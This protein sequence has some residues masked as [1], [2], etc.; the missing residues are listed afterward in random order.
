[1][2]DLFRDELTTYGQTLCLGLD[3]LTKG[4]VTSLP[5]EALVKAAVWARSAARVVHIDSAA[6]LAQAVED[7]LLAL[8]NAPPT[9]KD[10]AALRSAAELLPSLGEAAA[11]QALDD[12]LA[13]HQEE[14]DALIAQLRSPAPVPTRDAVAASVPTI[15]T[16]AVGQ[17]PPAAPSVPVRTA[18]PNITTGAGE[19]EQV[20]RVTAQSLTR[21]MG[22]AGEAL[23]QARWLQPFTR[24]LLRL[25]RQQAAALEALAQAQVA[26][27]REQLTACQHELDD[28]ISEFEEHARQADNLN[29]RLYR[30]VIASRMRPFGDVTHGFARLL[31]DLGRQLG[32][33]V[34]FEVIGESTEVDRDILD[35]LQAPLNH[36][37]R[38]AVDH[39]LEGPEDRLVAGKPE[40]GS[41]GLE[42]RHN[43]GMLS[44]QIRDDGCGI[45]TERIR[46][47]VVDRGLASPEMAAGLGQDELLEFLFLPG[48]STADQV[49][50]I[51]GR[52]VGLDVVLSMVRAVGGT[53]RISTQVGRGTT[54]HLQLPITLSVIRAVLAEV[55]GEPYAFPHNRINRL[56]RLPRAELGSLQDRQYFEVDGRTVGVVLAR[57]LFELGGDMPDGDDLSLVL[58]GDGAAEF[59][60]VVDRFL[61]E[62]DLVVRPLDPRLGKVPDLSAAAIL[63][64]GSPVLIVDLDDVGR[65]ISRLLQGA[66]LQRAEPAALVAAASVKRRVLVVDD[67]ITVREVQRQLLAGRGYEVEVAVDGMDGWNMVRRGGFDL[68]ITDVDMPRL[69]GLGLVRLIRADP[70]LQGLPIVIVSYKDQEEHR[71]AGLEA[72]ANYYLTK[73]SF[74][75]QRFL[76]AVTDLIGD[77]DS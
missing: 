62:Q 38:N 59:G 12:W 23:V 8:A 36:L 33:K 50:E 5:P 20:V 2:L 17:A 24:L 26:E 47:K 66:R 6:R 21:L 72:G 70:H 1:L 57:Q 73:S 63:E 67:S 53:V 11:G 58:F 61:G 55:A 40:T 25:K 54:F 29:S 44:L 32:K 22:L 46:K 10:L 65:S 74:H 49:T 76:Q 56:L 28:R 35:K 3:Q 60:L 75:D 39:G 45:S 43:A 77:P 42:A 16:P 51:S 4:P 14:L 27:V 68:V 30:E 19:A 41:L 69:D 52:G 71:L 64:D 31:R 18:P 37:L 9:P 7:R 15:A 34:R 48:F 13:E